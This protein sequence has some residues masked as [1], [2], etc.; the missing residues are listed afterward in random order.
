MAASGCTREWKTA[1]GLG[2]GLRED[3]QEHVDRIPCSIY[4]LARFLMMIAGHFKPLISFKMSI[5]LFFLGNIIPIDI[6]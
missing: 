3:N 4:S 1:S 2:R 6:S 5:K